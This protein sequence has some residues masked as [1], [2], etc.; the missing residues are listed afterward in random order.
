MSNIVSGLLAT[1]V[2]MP[3]AAFIL[4][5]MISRKITRRKKKSFH[6]AVN[7]STV[8]FIFGVHFFIMAIWE[9][10]YFWIIIIFLLLLKVLFMTGYWWKK[11]DLHIAAVFRIFWRFNFLLFFFVYF[12][13]LIYGL[14]TRVTENI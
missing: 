13:L 7:V 5:Y 10:S 11:K 12:G 4:L 3:I 2:T 9:K 6:F 8:F 1:L 14:I